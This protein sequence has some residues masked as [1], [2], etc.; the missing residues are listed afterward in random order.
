MDGITQRTWERL[1]SSFELNL[2]YGDHCWKDMEEKNGI[3]TPN[4]G[5]DSTKKREI[6]TLPPWVCYI[7]I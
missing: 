7:L 3:E 1:P 2:D 6:P 5:F 4:G